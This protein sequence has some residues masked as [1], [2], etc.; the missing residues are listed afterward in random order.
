LIDYLQ[1][2]GI[3]QGLDFHTVPKR[4]FLKTFFKHILEPR[5]LALDDVELAFI[6][7]FRAANGRLQ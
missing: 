1:S 5:E 4:E 2:E 7:S 3:V 6:I